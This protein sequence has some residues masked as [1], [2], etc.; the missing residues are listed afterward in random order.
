MSDPIIP[1][2]IDFVNIEEEMQ[3][4]YIDYSMSVIIGR[5]LPD[6]R[7]GLKPVNRRI[8][9]AMQQGGWSSG[10]PFVKCARVVGDVMGKYHPHG[11]S[12][13]YDALVRM[14]QDFS[15]R[16]PLIQSQGNFGSIDGDP[17]A[18]YRYT[19]CKLNRLSEELLA[20]IEKDTVDMR[21]TY[22]EQ[23][24][25]PSV[26]PTR[27]PNLLV[28]GSTGIAVGMATN[29][30]P[31]NLGEVVDA[32]IHL[33][34]HPESSIRDLMQ[35]VK[36]PDFP[37][38]GLLVG[39]N[40]VIKMYETGRGLLKLRGRATIEQ[41]AKGRETILITEIPYT[42]NKAMLISRMA[43]L[44]NE[45]KIE[46]ISDIR[47]ESSKE[48]IRVL[49]EIKRNAMGSVV[50]NNLYKHTQLEHTFGATL[51]AIDRNR[52]KVMNLRELLQCFL[53]HR[54]EVVTRR[55]RFDLAKAE[56]RAHILQGLL[57][58]LDHLD[59]VVKTIRASNSRDEARDNLIA[60][61]EFTEV[62][63]L[64]ILEMR[65]YQLTG[66]EREKVQAEYDA[67]Q[68]Q[69]AYYK[70]L[71]ADPAKIYG[72]IK[73]DLREIKGAYANPRLSELVPDEGEI[74][75]EDLI[76][77]RPCVISITHGGYIKRVPLDTYREQRRGGKGVIGMDTKEE[78]FVEHVFACST[79]DYLLVFTQQGHMYWL[80]G[81]AVPEAPRTSRGRAIANLLSIEASEKIASIVRVRDFPEDRY[82]VFATRTGIA[83]KTQLSA[84]KNIRAGGLKAV[85]IE[86]GDELIGVRLTN[87]S[88]EIMLVT[89]E[90]MSIRFPES[91]LRSMGRDTVGV[92]GIELA[93]EGDAVVGIEIPRPGATLLVM[94][95]NGYG[96]RTEFAEY[97]FQSRGGKGVITMQTTEKT[98][99]VVAAHTVD[100]AD[101]IM[102]ISTRGQMIRM[103]VD[104]IRMTGRNAQG[105]RLINLEEGDSLVA[106]APIDEEE[107]EVEVPADS[108]GTPP[109]DPTGPA[110]PDAPP[111]PE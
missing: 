43:E 7:D 39:V 3:R 80:K 85:K 110:A 104:G 109:V 18:A 16:A 55:T 79:H 41:D 71:L 92:W 77:D 11:D 22:D 107:K 102:L 38:S 14:A 101:S 35:F 105:V 59:E 69:I 42:V 44:V 33:V 2:K 81:Y 8:L 52:P 23:N 29:I 61:F 106:A 65:L 70:E 67:I 82:L 20:D 15:M 62:Q 17:A 68:A 103:P 48:G 78:D 98:G 83:K 108:A 51:L 12:A 36:G 46:G 95:E 54:F 26:L 56:A 58:A 50:L 74:N 97:R 91:D 53:D 64:A 88:D 40:E 28:N 75:F 31:H 13:I 63:A 86:E 1:A 90:G 100:D 87:G 47:D 66:L 99:K 89:R 111:S 34:D 4:D 60:R 21:R 9:Y 30:P 93:G 45:K 6:A 76:E 24:E 5:A 32:A 94:S 57:K 27:I 49:V 37:T 72:V 73:D 25:E 10:R 96:K 84:F 19:E